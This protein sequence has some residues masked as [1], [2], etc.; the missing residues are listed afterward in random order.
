[1]LAEFDRKSVEVSPHWI[2]VSPAFVEL[3]PSLDA[4]P[5]SRARMPLTPPHPFHPPRPAQACLCR[6]QTPQA[7]SRDDMI[8][9][10]AS[11]SSVQ[12]IGNL[13][14]GLGFQ[15][16]RTESVRSVHTDRTGTSASS[17]PVRRREETAR[18]LVER[19]L[20]QETARARA[21]ALAHDRCWWAGAV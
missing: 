5:S 11:R 3:T 10:S 1:M 14:D 2:K 6:P 18:S 13:A 19:A 7:A 8:S 15:E 20:P 12:D 21:H 9:E 16:S 4:R 17:N